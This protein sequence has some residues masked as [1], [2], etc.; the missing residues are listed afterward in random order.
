MKIFSLL[1]L[2]RQLENC[3][4]LANQVL[5]AKNW[6]LYNTVRGST[7][8]KFWILSVCHPLFIKTFGLSFVHIAI[9]S[10]KINCVRLSTSSNDAYI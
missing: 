7:V 1:D 2:D 6:N 5:D 4:N 3:Q 9:P 10:K 8:S